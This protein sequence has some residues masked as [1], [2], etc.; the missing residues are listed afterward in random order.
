MYTVELKLVIS[1][2]NSQKKERVFVSSTDQLFTAISLE[3]PNNNY[4]IDY[5]IDN[6]I[7]SIAKIDSKFYFLPMFLNI[8]KTPDLI[9]INYAILLPVD[10]EIS[11]NDYY[12][13]N[14]NIAIIDTLVRKAIAYV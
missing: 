10:T 13:V 6:F 12:I 11:L 9:S 14:K 4:S 5:T 7:R 8:D 1:F 3:L 2:F